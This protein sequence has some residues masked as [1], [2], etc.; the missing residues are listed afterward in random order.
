MNLKHQ[1]MAQQELNYKMKL[2]YALKKIDQLIFS[3]S[4]YKIALGYI[5]AIAGFSVSDSILKEF[6]VLNSKE[7]MNKEKTAILVG[8]ENF[9]TEFAVKNVSG[10]GLTAYHFS[11]KGKIEIIDKA[12]KKDLERVLKDSTYKNIVIYGHGSKGSWLDSD[13]YSVEYRDLKG[14]QKER[15]IQLTCGSKY[16]RSLAEMYAKNEK[17]SFYPTKKRS[18]FDN[19]LYGLNLILSDK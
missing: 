1:F 7:H 14:S 9:S 3:D 12:K 15:I 5:I 13:R 19:Y 17:E 10:L 18:A 8:Y 2:K 4:L 6:A 11:K 16:G